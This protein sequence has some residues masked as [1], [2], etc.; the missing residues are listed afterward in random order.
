MVKLGSAGNPVPVSNDTLWLQVTVGSTTLSPRRQL[1]SV[2]FA[3]RSDLSD[4]VGILPDLDVTGEA[5]VGNL[6]SNTVSLNQI[7]YSFTDTDGV[8]KLWIKTGSSNRTVTLPSPANNTGREIAVGK[9]D[10]GS[11]YLFIQSSGGSISGYT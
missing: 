6:Y 4:D 7:G 5:K 2:P 8:S 9:E 1:T 11:G 10:N 3:L